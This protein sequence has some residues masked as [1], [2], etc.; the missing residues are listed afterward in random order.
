MA[1]YLSSLLY[2]LLFFLDLSSS[3]PLSV[4]L[5]LFFLVDLFLQQ[6][7]VSLSSGVGLLEQVDPVLNIFSNLLILDLIVVHDIY[8]VLQNVL[9]LFELLEIAQH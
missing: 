8:S 1:E 3:E 5:S 2:F 4:P 6:S 7:L 9:F